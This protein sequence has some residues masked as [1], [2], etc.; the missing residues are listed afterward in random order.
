MLEDAFMAEGLGRRSSNRRGFLFSWLKVILISALLLSFSSYYFLTKYSQVFLEKTSA[1]RFFILTIT[2]TLENDSPDGRIWN[3]SEEEKTIGLFVNNSRQTVYLLN[4]SYPVGDVQLDADGN[5]TA[6]LS[7]P[8]P[9]ISK[10]RN[11]TL[12]IVYKIILKPHPFPRIFIN[13]SGSLSDINED[14]KARYCRNIGPWRMD[15]NALRKLASQIVGNETNILLLLRDLIQWIKHNVHYETGDLPRYPNE[16]LSGKAGD[17]DDQANLFIALCRALGIPAYLQM[18]CIYL[19]SYD[20]EASHW[21]GHWKLK[22][23]RVG[24]HGWAMVYVPPWGWIPVDLTFAPGI[25]SDPM[26]AIKK[27]AVIVYPVVQYANI[28]E[29]DYIAS[30]RSYCEFLLSN[31]FKIYEEDV[32]SEIEVSPQ[33]GTVRLPCLHVFACLPLSRFQA[34]LSI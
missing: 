21:N 22:L 7:F 30:T 9:M 25:L 6:H 27:A 26:N 18:G 10:G 5:P 8:T 32:M 12:Q 13:Q 19:P 28:T 29:T 23:T 2:S 31:G 14:L 34:S 24:W 20:L 4:A 11:L 3:L 1:N 15:R 16:T 17:C 33:E